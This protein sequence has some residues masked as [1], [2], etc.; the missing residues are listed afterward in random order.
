MEAGSRDYK[1]VLAL[2]GDLGQ[3]FVLCLLAVLVRGLPV[4]CDEDARFVQLHVGRIPVGS[5]A[6]YWMGCD[7]AIGAV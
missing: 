2:T 7:L 1:E 5:D 4:P 3:V 6:K